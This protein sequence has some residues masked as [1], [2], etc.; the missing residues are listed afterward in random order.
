MTRRNFIV[1]YLAGLL[2]ATVVAIVAPLLVFIYPPQGQTQTKDVTI[3]LDKSITDLA[4]T[5]ATK[6]LSPPETGFVMKDGG[7][8]NAPGKVAFG[9]YVAKDA[10]GNVNVFAINCSHLGCSIAWTPADQLFECPCHGSRFNIN[11]NVVHGPAAYPLSNLTWKQGA[12]ASEIIVQS[13][14]LKGIG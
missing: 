10:S 5:D 12:T 2:T 13:Y 8:D 9:G 14:T 7:G 3:R 4:N 11:G 6:F 1:W